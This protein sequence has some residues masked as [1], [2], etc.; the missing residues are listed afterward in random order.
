MMPVTEK[1]MLL[2]VI[3]DSIE[4][5]VVDFLIGGKG[6]DY[7]KKD[8]ADGCGISRPTLYKALPS[9]LKHGV[10]KSTRNIGRIKL[11]T[12]NTENEKVKALLKLETFLLN[13][14]FESIPGKHSQ[15]L[16][17]HVAVAAV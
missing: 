3:G 12:L 8:M 9:L 1:S 15:V 16:R 5:R 11:F 13:Q 6:L 2:E 4:N 7:S 10:V 14:S 17:Q